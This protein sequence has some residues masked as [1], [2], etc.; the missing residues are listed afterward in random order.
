MAISTPAQKPRGDANRTLSTA[1]KS[2]YRHRARRLTGMA[3]PLV[4]AVAP[5]SPAARGGVEPGDEI[6]ELNGRRP[7]DVIEW[8][9]AVDDPEVELLVQRGGLQLDLR[10]ER[11]TGEPFGV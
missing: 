5:S 2:G 7:R 10:V 8:Q 11:G 4:V 1:T 6:L 9:L 3:L